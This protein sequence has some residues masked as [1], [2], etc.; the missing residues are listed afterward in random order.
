MRISYGKKTAYVNFVIAALL[1]LL[2]Y[3]CKKNDTVTNSTPGGTS[4]G[5]INQVVMQNSTFMPASLTV[6]AGTTVTWTNKDAYEHTVTS[7]TPNAPD[8]KFDSGTIASG[9]TFS[10]KFDAK[11]TYSY[12][13]KVHP[14]VMV[15]TIVVQ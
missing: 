4:T 11:G 12:Y 6:P 15:G 2:A 9:K 1:L 10:Y 3:G 5:N 8:G 13:C 7:G 14:E